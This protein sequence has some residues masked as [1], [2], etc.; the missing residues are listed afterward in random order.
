MALVIPFCGLHYN[1]KLLETEA[2]K[3]LAPPYDVV[4]SS[5]RDRI[6]SLSPYNI[7]NLELPEEGENK[8]QRAA[9]LFKEWKDSGVIVQDEQCA[10]Y[11]YTIEFE[12]QGAKFKRRGFIGLVR[13]EE[14]EKR[15]IRPHEQIF[16]QV[17]SD[18]LS[19]FKATKAQFSQV[20]LLYRHNDQA[21][22]IIAQAP[23]NR[24]VSVK[25]PLGNQHVLERITD[26][27]A[28]RQLTKALKDTI[29][30]IADG[31]HRYTTALTYKKLME[32]QE[33]FSPFS[34]SNF[35]MAYFV[36]T[37]DEGLVV[38][39]THRLFQLPPKLGWEAI[40]NKAKEY[41]DFEDLDLKAFDSPEALA[42]EIEKQLDQAGNRHGFGV[43]AQNGAYASIWW[44]K[45]GACSLKKDHALEL[46]K[47]DV[48]VLRKCV[49]ETLLEIS[50]GNL[51]AGENVRFEPDGVKAVKELKK[52]EVLFYLRPTPVEQVLDVSDAGLTLPHK[53]TF[54][55]PKIL[56]GLVL[57]DLDKEAP[58]LIRDLIC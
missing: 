32:Q 58:E 20:F 41:F 44:L 3:L 23:K 40:L 9:Q 36:D 48:V 50:P 29:M 27:D 42:K 45:E 54:F 1:K 25:D 43:V 49:V 16:E 34:G 47:L 26:P 21:K 56:T 7:F 13:L 39:P 14:W 22:Q 11:P 30:Y 5:L 10:V 35:L 55:Y 12:H 53:S 19:L 37:S 57:N 2:E 31:H 28:L 17:T 33:G 6:A 15:I 24:L 18:R 46:A 52:N 4:N 8:Y 51:K 38:L